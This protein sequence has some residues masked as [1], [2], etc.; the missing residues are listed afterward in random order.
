M[1]IAIA[2]DHR[3]VKL[4]HQ[5]INYLE[6]KKIPYMNEGTNND[7]SVDYPTYAKKVCDR[8]KNKEADYGILICGTG[9]GM[10]IAAN[11]IKG[12]RCAKVVNKKEA[13]FARDHNNANVIALSENTAEVESIVNT[14]INSEYSNE[15]KHNRRN[16]M[17]GDLENAI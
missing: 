1:K 4:K 3:G 12:I 2:S 6:T 5:I 16:K 8:I 7:I 11:K 10:S 9:I 17:I 15:E 13:F 14:F